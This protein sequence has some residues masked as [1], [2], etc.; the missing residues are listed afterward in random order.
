[1]LT[2]TKWESIKGKKDDFREIIPAIPKNKNKYNY[3]NCLWIIY[4][5]RNYFSQSEKVN[6]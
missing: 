1:M 6:L 2:E 5:I 3:I 4:E